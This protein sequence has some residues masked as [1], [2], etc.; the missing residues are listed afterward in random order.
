MKTLFYRSHQRW[1]LPVNASSDLELESTVTISLINLIPF[2]IFPTKRSCFLRC[3]CRLHLL[4]NLCMLM[5]HPMVI[6]RNSFSSMKRGKSSMFWFSM[7][8]IFFLNVMNDDTK[9]LRFSTRIHSILWSL[10]NLFLSTYPLFHLRTPLYLFTTSLLSKSHLS[11]I[12]LKNN[13]LL[14]AS[15]NSSS[16]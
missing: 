14:C 11:S 13:L 4:P 2:P 8:F 16:P 5:I 9:S 1:F 10:H 6:S 3:W 12:F 7:I 15:Y